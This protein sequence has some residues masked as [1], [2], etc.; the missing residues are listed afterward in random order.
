M[1]CDDDVELGVPVDVRCDFDVQVTV[2]PRIAI[3]SASTSKVHVVSVARRLDL[4]ENGTPHHDKF[5][6]FEEINDL[7]CLENTYLHVDSLVPF[8]EV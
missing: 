2:Q 4:P 3:C 6:L 1:N 8:Y 7:D 5:K